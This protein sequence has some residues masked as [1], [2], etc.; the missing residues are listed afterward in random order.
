MTRT[1]YNSRNYI[2]AIA[3][4]LIAKLGIFLNINKLMHVK[5]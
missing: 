3:S 1:I 5:N 4:N 2:E